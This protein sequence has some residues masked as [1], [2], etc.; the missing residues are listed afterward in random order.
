MGLA[1]LCKGGW[2]VLVVIVTLAAE[3]VRRRK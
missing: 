1:G 2:S 3:V